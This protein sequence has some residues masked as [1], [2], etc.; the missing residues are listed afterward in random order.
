VGKKG[1]RKPDA[2]PVERGRGKGRQ[3]KGKNNRNWRKVKR[4]PKRHDIL[5]IGKNVNKL[6]QLGQKKDSGGRGGGGQKKKKAKKGMRVVRGGGGKREN[7]S[8]VAG[9]KGRRISKGSGP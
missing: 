1:E 8:F 9:W 7:A 6:I 5:G 2:G 3:K 4:G